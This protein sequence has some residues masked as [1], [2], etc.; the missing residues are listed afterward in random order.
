MG[1]VPLVG[2]VLEYN[3][4]EHVIVLL[5]DQNFKS[6]SFRNRV[7]EPFIIRYTKFLH[8]TVFVIKKSFR[9]LFQATESIHKIV[10]H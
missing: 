2:E 7:S 10:L 5:A 4:L 1:E 9:R 8:F 6:E 3:I